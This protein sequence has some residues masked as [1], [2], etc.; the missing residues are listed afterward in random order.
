MPEPQEPQATPKADAKPAQANVVPPTK[1]EAP[2]QPEIDWKAEARKWEERA[3][4][5]AEA[6]KRLDEIE[7]ASKSD[8]EKATEARQAAEQERDA[9][10]AEALRYKVASKHGISDEDAELFLTGTDEDTLTKQAE[11]LAARGEDAGK[12][13]PPKP[14]VNQGRNGNGAGLTTAQ[15]FATAIEGA[16]NH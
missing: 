4:E 10:R 6:R 13:R 12:P 3:K 8:L 9:A 1:P 15:Q 16:L 14:D 5:N 2:A 7:A 11:R